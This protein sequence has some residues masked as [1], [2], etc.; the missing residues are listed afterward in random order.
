MAPKIRFFYQSDCPSCH[1]GKAFLHGHQIAA[2]ERDLGKD[3]LTAAEL[4]ELIGHHLVTDFLNTRSDSFRAFGLRENLPPR[5]E[6]LRLMGEHA[7]LIL[8]PILV[9]DG[10]VVF[11]FDEAT[12]EA[13][14]LHASERTSPPAFRAGTRR[15]P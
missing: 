6:A 5:A 11:G 1:E 2:E 15:R 4:D 14:L 8:R 3:P 7:D 10:R 13:L 9:V 12:W